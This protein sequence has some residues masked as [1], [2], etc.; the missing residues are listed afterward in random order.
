MTGAGAVGDPLADPPGVEVEVPVDDE[1]EDEDEDDEDEDEGDEDEDAEEDEYLRSFINKEKTVS[2]P[3]G[4]GRPTKRVKWV[5][6]C[7]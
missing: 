2:I 7:F 3:S 5:R 1:D 6:T 4:S